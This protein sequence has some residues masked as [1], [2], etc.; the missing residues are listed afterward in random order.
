MRKK[1]YYLLHLSL[2]LLLLIFLFKS[3][4]GLFADWQ[5]VKTKLYFSPLNKLQPNKEVLDHLVKGIYGN[6]ALDAQI[7]E[8]LKRYFILLSEY[9]PERSDAFGMKGLCLYYQGQI[10]Q[11]EEAYQKAIELNPHFF[12]FYYNLG[13]IHMKDNNYPAAMAAFK[14]GL[15]TRP[16]HALYYIQTS[17]KVYL[18]ILKSTRD[19]WG[20]EPQDQLKQGYQDCLGLLLLAQK[21]KEAP[22]SV[23]MPDEAV[24][25]A[26]F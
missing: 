24:P 7:L 17:E 14:Q 5:R 2:T 19:L 25:L 15:Q 1:T 26:I 10:P 21:L 22:D 12:W 16:E 23:E 6:Q 13:V 18:P 3:F 11:A 20:W 8:R 9:F 4:Q